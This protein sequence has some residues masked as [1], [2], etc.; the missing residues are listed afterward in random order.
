MW[1]FDILVVIPTFDLH[2]KP[3]ITLVTADLIYKFA[4]SPLPLWGEFQHS[5][6]GASYHTLWPALSSMDPR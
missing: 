4:A 1:I 3:V 5:R 6:H 2:V